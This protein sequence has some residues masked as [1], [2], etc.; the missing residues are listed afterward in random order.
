VESELNKGTTFTV[1]LPIHLGADQ[2]QDTSQ[3]KPTSGEG[4]ET[5]LLVEDDESIRVLVARILRRK[6][7]AVLDT[8]DAGEALLEAEGHGGRID[9]LLSDVV[10]PLMSGI[11]LASRIRDSRPDIKVLLMSGYPESALTPEE[12]ETL[13]VHFVAKPVDPPELTGRIREILDC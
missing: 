1:C 5:V 6:G 13:G 10:M 9:L 11:R 2:N 4:T 12:C 7:Y 8:S 3:A